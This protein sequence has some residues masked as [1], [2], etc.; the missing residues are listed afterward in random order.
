[1]QASKTPIVPLG[2]TPLT[3]R[4]F[5]LT[6]TAAEL[7]LAEVPCRFVSFQNP[8]RLPNGDANVTSIFVGDDLFVAY[9]IA[10]GEASPFFPVTRL[11]DLKI[12]TAGLSV[13]VVLALLVEAK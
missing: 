11:N 2:N 5:V 4:F 9:E 12:R 6:A 3:S 8:A 1:M 13:P 10:P 7:R